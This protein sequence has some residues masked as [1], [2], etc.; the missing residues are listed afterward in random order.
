MPDTFNAAGLT[1]KTATEITADLVAALQG[2]YGSDINT[3]QNSPDGQLIG[4]LTQ[5]AVDIRELAVNVNSGFDPDTAQGAT[6]DQRV[7]IN[8]IERLGGTYTVQ[9]I[10]IT[11]NTTVTLTGLDADY[12]NPLGTGYTV[13]D[14][15]GNQFILVDT[16]I[17]T[18]G[19]TSAN[20]R[21]KNIGLV[22][23]P[24]DTITTPVTI[25][26]GVTGVNNSSS[27]ITVGQ[28]Q[29]TDAQLRT[30]RA[31]SVAIASTGYLNGLLGAVLNLDG[32]TSGV[33]YENV[34][35][36]TDADGIPAH[37][38]WLVAA[39]GANSDIGD[40]IYAK[41]SYGAN[42][43]G[44][45]EV[46]ITTA[47]GEIFTAK[48]DRPT[49]KNL[50]IRFDIQTTVAGTTFDTLGIENYIADN[51]TY[52]IGAYSETSSITAIALAGI[53]A[54]SGGGVPLNVEIS[55]DGITWADYLTVTTLDE[56]WTVDAS[57]IAITEL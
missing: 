53:N 28:N 40:L 21:A 42:M 56:Q 54:T 47:S 7:T 24:V 49:P 35:N 46:D 41:K 29:E 18:S 38:I 4:I 8:N 39:G 9:P 33:L 6:L 16:T 23:V 13:Q 17:F 14:S 26:I 37:G 45:V 2:I 1:V 5:A 55:D 43:K 34:T 20:F 51:L 15:S 3:D 57:R 50:Y 52:A 44:T 22:D 11:T 30:R 27:A 12:A 19:T 36:V 48:F 10:D 25:V 31:R 32:V